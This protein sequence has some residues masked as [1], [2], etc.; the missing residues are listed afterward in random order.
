MF[1]KL[2]LFSFPAKPHLLS[3]NS[4]S[5]VLLAL[6]LAKKGEQAGPQDS[7]SF[8]GATAAAGVC[9]P[10]LSLPGSCFIHFI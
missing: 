4:L 9:F 3:P 10:A 5:D 6:L 8:A 1:P 2:H 7:P